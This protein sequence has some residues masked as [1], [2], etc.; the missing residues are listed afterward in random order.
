MPRIVAPLR[1]TG[2]VEVEDLLGRPQQVLDREAMAAT[3]DEYAPEHLT[4]QAEDLDFL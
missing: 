1:R 3:S 2:P 4:V